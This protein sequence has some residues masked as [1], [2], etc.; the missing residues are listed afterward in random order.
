LSQ[1]AS[2]DNFQLNKSF[3]L[4]L[5]SLAEDYNPFVVTFEI[6]QRRPSVN[7]KESDQAIA[8]GFWEISRNSETSNKPQ[9]AKVILSLKENIEKLSKNIV[10]A[11]GKEKQQPI[12][13]QL[14]TLFLNYQIS[15]RA[16]VIPSPATFENTMSSQSKGADQLLVLSLKINSI[17]G[18]TMASDFLV[19]EINGLCGVDKSSQVLEV[20]FSDLHEIRI[21]FKR[22]FYMTRQALLESAKRTLIVK[23]IEKHSGDTQHHLVGYSKISLSNLNAISNCKALS[24]DFASPPIQ[25]ENGLYELTT[26][27]SITK[28]FL[29]IDIVVGT[30]AWTDNYGSKINYPTQV[31]LPAEKIKTQN[32]KNSDLIEI[33]EENDENLNIS[34]VDHDIID[35]IQNEFQMENSNVMKQQKNNFYKKVVNNRNE[36]H[37]SEPPNY[38]NQ[39]KYERN[40]K[41][42]YQ[43]N[44]DSQN[45]FNRKED[46]SVNDS[47]KNQTPQRSERKDLKNSQTSHFLKKKDFEGIDNIFNE[48]SAMQINMDQ[49]NIS[50][51]DEFHNQLPMSEKLKTPQPDQFEKAKPNSVQKPPRISPMEQFKI[52]TELS[53][54]NSLMNSKSQELDSEIIDRVFGEEVPRKLSRA[55]SIRTERKQ[56]DL[57]EKSHES[58]YSLNQENHSIKSNE[59]S[60]DFHQDNNDSKN[61]LNKRQA[62]KQVFEEGE[63]LT[64]NN[65]SQSE[66]ERDFELANDQAPDN[67]V[68]VPSQEFSNRIG[69]QTFNPNVMELPKPSALNIERSGKK[70]SCKSN[71]NLESNLKIKITNPLQILLNFFDCLI[72]TD[73]SE[74][75][76]ICKLKAVWSYESTYEIIQESRLPF[77]MDEVELLFRFLDPQ[78]TGFLPLKDILESVDRFLDLKISLLYFHFSEL[79]DYC[80]GK[81]YSYFIEQIQ[82][83][84]QDNNNNSFISVEKFN[85]LISKC[86]V[87]LPVQIVKDLEFLGFYVSEDQVYIPNIINFLTLASLGVSS[88]NKPSSSLI[89]KI[90]SL[91]RS[92]ILF[93]FD[94]NIYCECENRFFMQEICNPVILDEL[95][96]LGN[97]QNLMTV[98]EFYSKLKDGA[99]GRTKMKLIDYYLLFVKVQ[100]F[101]GKESEVPFRSSV[102]IQNLQDLVDQEKTPA[103]VID[104]IDY[105]N[106]I[107]NSKAS[108]AKD[109]PKS[110]S[111]FIPMPEAKKEEKQ[112]KS[113]S[114]QSRISQPLNEIEGESNGILPQKS[115]ETPNEEIETSKSSVIDFQ[116]N[117][118]NLESLPIFFSGRLATLRF[119]LQRGQ[120]AF[121]SR[122]FILDSDANALP[123]DFKTSFKFKAKSPFDNPMQFFTDKNI[124]FIEI[125]LFL[126]SP[127]RVNEQFASALVPVSSGNDS[128][129]SPSIALITPLVSYFQKF[130][131]DFKGTHLGTLGY[132]FH[133]IL[134]ND[135]NDAS[136]SQSF[137][138][139]DIRAEKEI[140]FNKELP[141]RGTLIFLIQRLKL[142][143]TL[144]FLLDNPEVKHFKSNSRAM[145]ALHTFEL[146]LKILP[147]S[148]SAKFCS[149]MSKFEYSI[150]QKQFSNDQ[151]LFTILSNIETQSLEKNLLKTDIHFSQEVYEYFE[152]SKS[153]IFIEYALTEGESENMIKGEI[154]MGSFSLKD[155]ISSPNSDGIEL[156]VDLHSGQNLRASTVIH[157]NYTDNDLYTSSIIALEENNQNERLVF[158]DIIGISGFSASLSNKTMKICISGKNTINSRAFTLEQEHNHSALKIADWHFD[159]KL[160]DDN[161]NMI[162]IRGNNQKI[163]IEIFTLNEDA[164]YQSIYKNL[165]NPELLKTDSRRANSLELKS[166]VVEIG[167]GELLLYMRIFICD[168]NRINH[169]Q[170]QKICRS[171]NS[172]LWTEDFRSY[173]VFKS[174]YPHEIDEKSKISSALTAKSD[175]VNFVKRKYQSVKSEMDLFLEL[176]KVDES[177]DQVDL[178][179]IFPPWRP[180]SIPR[181]STHSMIFRHKDISDLIQDFLFYDEEFS[182]Y[183]EEIIF[184]Q[185]SI[186]HKD[187]ITSLIPFSEFGQSSISKLFKGLKY[188]NYVS[189]ISIL[190]KQIGF[191]ITVHPQLANTVHVNN[192]NTQSL[193]NSALQQLF[194]TNPK[195]EDSKAILDEYASSKLKKSNL[196]FNES[197]AES[198]KLDLGKFTNKI[199]ISIQSVTASGLNSLSFNNK[200]PNSLVDIHITGFCPESRRSLVSLCDSD[201]SFDSLGSFKLES[202]DSLIS[203]YRNPSN[204]L[205]LFIRE[206]SSDMNQSIRDYCRSEINFSLN[207][208]LPLSEFTKFLEISN[209][210]KL[211]HSQATFTC[212]E[213]DKASVSIHIVVRKLG[214]KSIAKEEIVDT[215]PLNANDDL[216]NTLMTLREIK[217]NENNH[218][219]EQTPAFEDNLFDFIKKNIQTASNNGLVNKEENRGKP[220]PDK[221]SNIEAENQSHLKINT[222]S[223]KDFSEVQ[224]LK[225]ESFAEFSNKFSQPTMQLNQG[226]DKVTDKDENPL[227]DSSPQIPDD[228]NYIT[229]KTNPFVQ[230]LGDKIADYESVNNNES[231]QLSDISQDK[232][233]HLSFKVPDIES[234]FNNQ[235]NRDPIENATSKLSSQKKVEGRPNNDD[236]ASNRSIQ[237]IQKIPRNLFTDAEMSRI[238]RMINS[239]RIGPDF[240]NFDSEDEELNKE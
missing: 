210:T 31:V 164:N 144:C 152:S 221:S 135:S 233:P 136:I 98:N 122:S 205:K 20:L 29:D 177:T 67:L 238:S 130:G 168:Q 92:S 183:V 100:E 81:D 114:K 237:L 190:I 128:C 55:N 23:L 72:E 148:E 90:D 198:R 137:S 216:H 104:E 208:F 191:S 7:G 126:K 63:N 15:S 11:K 125:G 59:L 47:R 75:K 43:S 70:G 79:V 209:P 151:E 186:S 197:L 45:D 121:E 174:N 120:D 65:H 95:N 227:K 157:A 18:Y 69:F 139:N 223:D 213:F 71:S 224:G 220:I 103:P 16:S 57:D 105:L 129:G 107:F 117:R 96:S 37:S 232:V 192:F 84:Y 68:T 111:S 228:D 181:S 194:A 133:T 83:Q 235:I 110:S 66:E 26:I 89:K 77:G 161:N 199:E 78:E 28:A 64:H 88:I 163:E 188:C 218:Q 60:L 2:G 167:N 195:V 160:F 146:K 155:L 173:Q 87:D 219:F 12:P 39:V 13:K 138:R 178:K 170:S 200:K 112:I 176:L 5:T 124:Q 73:L 3:S 143:G 118:I 145:N 234:S 99:L 38:P 9:T 42:E 51:G 61:S 231:R 41:F 222:K 14:G 46:Q 215:L 184:D 85:K 132:N 153:S 206:F 21:N 149:N 187:A 185:I 17:K 109:I 159:Q 165:L 35:G 22:S 97:T 179:G 217:G 211:I 108:L 202:I 239:K 93:K 25:I 134:T 240:F 34:K 226:L 8:S 225:F 10:G 101:N 52:K 1:E 24:E 106:E 115:L 158:V 150:F 189:A 54:R 169:S 171:I 30:L 44:K 48:A 207:E 131:I 127:N 53:K 229:N 141:V 36:F 116:I 32:N 123:I 86:G 58:R 80:E 182:G 74:V 175:F 19:L 56:L 212:K 6:M 230:C 203:N 180:F 204:S 91:M 119:V 196:Y 142:N 62:I 113:V 201:P 102:S 27:D 162:P 172:I 4:K 236:D 40:S 156:F 49:S 94:Q 147:F 193:A 50:N 214:L 76:S 82:L 140:I 166:S 33:N 154:C